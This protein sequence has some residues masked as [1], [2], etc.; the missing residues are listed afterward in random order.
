[1]LQEGKYEEK[2]EKKWKVGDAGDIYTSGSR[3]RKHGDFSQLRG[4]SLME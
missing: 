4:E 2:E 1:M 3:L